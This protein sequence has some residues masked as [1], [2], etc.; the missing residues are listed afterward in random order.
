MINPPPPSEL[1]DPPSSPPLSPEPA[2]PPRARSQ[3]PNPSMGY[4]DQVKGGVKA[5]GQGV[6]WGGRAVNAAFG[7][8][9]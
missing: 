3:S 5:V 8:R 2:F 1:F 7:G 9:G 6:G 4:L